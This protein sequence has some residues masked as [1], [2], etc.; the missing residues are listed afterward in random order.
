[1]CDIGSALLTREEIVDI[2]GEIIPPMS[3]IFDPGISSHSKIASTF[4]KT[5]TDEDKCARIEVDWNLAQWG[6]DKLSSERPLLQ[7][8]CQIVDN[9]FNENFGSYDAFLNFILLTIDSID[10]VFTDNLIYGLRPSI[11]FYQIKPDTTAT[12]SQTQAVY[13]N[14]IL[15][16]IFNKRFKDN[17]K[18]LWKNK[19]IK[20]A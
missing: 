13:D 6:H 11:Y 2:H 19:G 3:V 9:W 16:A 20:N 4:F 5:S 1:M 18:R 15:L 8:E 12:D 14:Y 17:W 10:D 7:S